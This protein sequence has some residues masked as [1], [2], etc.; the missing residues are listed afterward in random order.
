MTLNDF[1]IRFVVGSIPTTDV[2]K[3]S[4]AWGSATV[5]VRVT[6]LSR[7]RLPLP[8]PLPL[9]L[10]GGPPLSRLSSVSSRRHGFKN[11]EIFS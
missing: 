9:P 3:G 10:I 7:V 8:P 2:A 1:P 4:T 5:P 11:Q 6:K